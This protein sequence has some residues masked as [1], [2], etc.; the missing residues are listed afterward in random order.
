MPAVCFLWHYPDPSQLGRW[1][2]P[3]TAPCGV[4]TFLP[5]PPVAVE[6]SRR[7]SSPPHDPQYYYAT[8][9]PGASLKNDW[10][11]K[12]RA[13]LLTVSLNCPNEL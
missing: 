1:V 10:M 4:R 9:A 7:S 3:T 12:S 2:L 6:E 8:E 5:V 13:I 11:K